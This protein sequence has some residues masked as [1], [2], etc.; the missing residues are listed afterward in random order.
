[1]LAK[2]QL[3]GRVGIDALYGPTETLVL[4]DDNASPDLVAADLLAQAEHDVLATPVLITV[5]RG[6][7]EAVAAQV[8]EQLATLEREPIARA[9][10]ERGGAVVAADLDQA[11][12]LANEFAPE[13]LCLLVQDAESLVP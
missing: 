10:V 13:H 1:T 2:Q 4:A 12:E 9:A 7:A 3:F 5:S 8:D 6:M 11:L